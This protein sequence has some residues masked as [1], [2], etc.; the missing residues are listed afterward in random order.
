MKTENE[1]K[2]QQEIVQYIRKTYCKPDH[3]PRLVCMSVPNGIGL[4]VPNSVRVIVEKA[5]AGAVELMKQI[6][7]TVG[8]SDLQIHG[9][10]GRCMHI[11]VKTSK[12]KQSEDQIKFQNRI[13]QLDGKYFLVRSLDDVKK[14]NFDWLTEK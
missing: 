2:I 4:S 10:Q 1:S 12:G 5:T 14:I 13:Q 3:N 8:A 9:V 7:L 6:G 11:E